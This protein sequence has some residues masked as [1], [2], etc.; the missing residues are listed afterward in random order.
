MIDLDCH[1]ITIAG[2]V[3]TPTRGVWRL[4]VYL[5][6]HPGFVRSHAQIMDAIGI[7]EDCVDAAVLSVVKRA[8][9]Q[10]VTYI[11]THR[12]MGYSWQEL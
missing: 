3:I 8:R 5:A 1:T 4:C 9:Q 6:A 7:S 2:R 12:G 10:G 11:R